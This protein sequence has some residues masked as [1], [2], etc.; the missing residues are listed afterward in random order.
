M[1]TNFFDYHYYRVAKFYYKR[2]GSDATT[3]IISVSSVQGWLMVNLL[4]FLKQLLF[5]SEKFKYGWIFLTLIMILILFYNYRKYTNKYLEFRN[6]WVN[7][8]K[9]KRSLKGFIIILTIIFAWSLLFMNLFLINIMKWYVDIFDNVPNLVMSI[10]K[11]TSRWFS[12]LIKKSN[13]NKSRQIP[14]L[15]YFWR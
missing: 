4:I 15:V 1:L 8:D 10:F 3:A 12:I 2:D 6:K 7:E 11:N 13:Q 9:R 5:G 14:T